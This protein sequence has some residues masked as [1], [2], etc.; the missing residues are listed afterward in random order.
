MFINRTTELRFLAD[1]LVR[2]HP[3]PGQFVML[4]GRR[5]VGK[6]TIAYNP[7]TR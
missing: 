4:Y 6:P 7:T 2:E 1:V 5:R 3:G